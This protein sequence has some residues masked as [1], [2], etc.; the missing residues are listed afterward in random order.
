MLAISPV[1]RDNVQRLLI[2]GSANCGVCLNAQISYY[3]CPT[4]CKSASTMN[5]S[6]RSFIAIESLNVINQNFSICSITP[7]NIGLHYETN[8]N[9]AVAGMAVI[10]CSV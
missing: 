6:F 2:P 8:K 9:L 10:C 7:N 1:Q 5:S 4:V 3:R